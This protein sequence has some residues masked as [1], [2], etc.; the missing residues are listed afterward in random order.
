MKP[1]NPNPNDHPLLINGPLSSLY[2]ELINCRLCPRIVEFRERIARE[3]RKQFR[4]W[5]YWGRPIPGFGDVHAQLLILGL[6][7]AAHGGNRTGRVFT[8]DKS[9]DFLI[10]CL[11]KFNPIFPRPTIAIFKFLI[12]LIFNY[13]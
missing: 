10:K 6:G 2:S 7:P 9:A 12:F 11:Y 5:M 4:N 13:Q 3:K 8:G 1:H